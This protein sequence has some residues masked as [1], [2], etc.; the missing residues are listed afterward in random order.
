MWTNSLVLQF[1]AQRDPIEAVI[2]HARQVVLEAVQEGWQGPPFD[3]V[4]LADILGIHTVARDDLLDARVIATEDG[5]RIEY[6]PTRPLGRLRYSI[7]HE[8]SHTFFP[9][10]SDRPRHRTATGALPGV[11]DNWQLE[12]LCNIAAGELLVPTL[13]LPEEALGG[14]TADINLLMSLRARFGV[15]TEAML[16]RAVQ[17]ANEAVTMFAAAPTAASYGPVDSFRID[18]TA[19]SSQWDASLHRGRIIRSE[20]LG[21]CTAVGFTA[22]GTEDWGTGEGPVAVQAVGIP[23]YPSHRLPRVAGLLQKEAPVRESNRFDVVVGDATRPRGTG[24]KMIVHIVNNHARAFGG[25]GFANQLGR[26]V[27]HSAE[28]FRAWTIARPD[29]LVLGSVHI[30]D[31]D[32]GITVASMVAQQ[33]YGDSASTRL[34]YAAL[35]DCLVKVRHAA[36]QRRATVHM[37]PIGTGSGKGVW[38]LVVAEVKHA[39]CR[40]GVDVTVYVPPGEETEILNGPKTD[41]E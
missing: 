12:L 6:N 38:E 39:L 11:G 10:S 8:I 40:E 36:K 31:L 41:A 4:E 32:D 37:P 35:S 33:G 28:T 2:D 13:A 19:P 5:L 3:P 14:A 29:N 26:N 1:A 25:G 15:S 23:P 22:K 16:R 7:A 30:V 9:G 20:V 21:H 17:V 34:R 24:P 27:R 18:Y